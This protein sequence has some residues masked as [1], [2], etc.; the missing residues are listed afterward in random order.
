M[1]LLLLMILAVLLIS[2]TFFHISVIYGL[3]LW[4][5]LIFFYGLCHG[6]TVTS[7]F[8]VILRKLSSVS[9]VLITFSLIGMLS[10]VLRSCG[11]ISL[12]IS[13]CS[14]L[15]W[16]KLVLP[17]AFV[18]CSFMSLCTGSAFASV[19]SIGI[20][21][22]S[23][24]HMAGIPDVLLYGAILSG[25]Y[26]GDRIS[27]VSSSA[28]LVSEISD[29]SL[30]DNVHSMVS[31]FSLP[32]FTTLLLYILLGLVIGNQRIHTSLHFQN[33]S[34]ICILPVILILLFSY[35]KLNSRLILGCAIL[36]GLLITLLRTPLD[37]RAAFF[38][39]LTGYHAPDA[40]LAMLNGGGMLSMFRPILIILI[41]TC[42]VAV[43]EMTDFLKPVQDFLQHL[44]FSYIGKSIL[45]SVFSSMLAGSQ[46]LAVILSSIL[47]K[48]ETDHKKLA[49]T[50]EDTSIL[51]PAMIPWSTAFSVPAAALSATVL[52]I[53][54]AFYLYLVPLY[55]WMREGR[56]LCCLS[57]KF[58]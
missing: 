12:V 45:V 37:V 33:I 19:A 1:E 52:C 39:L 22:A 46:T 31:R 41:A 20:I 47:L 38:L 57:E 10:A 23:V 32:F 7:L 8:P 4:L 43:F 14:H 21:C 36:T 48:E 29:F 35:L 50:L 40:E 25:I 24:G 30:Y 17:A 58:G 9:G 54:F 5:I 53:P 55:A 13:L 6:C 44:N 27:P 2:S 28:A 15:T 49:D 34:W 51:I 11:S 26:V 3:F 42:Y 56:L 18:L 16:G